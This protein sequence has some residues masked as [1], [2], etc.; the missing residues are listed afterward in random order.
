MYERNELFM[1]LRG[2][3]R[4][5]ETSEEGEFAALVALE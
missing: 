5:R 3:W 1:R 4:E 2:K